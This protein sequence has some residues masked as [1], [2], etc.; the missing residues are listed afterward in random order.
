[1]RLMQSSLKYSLS[2]LMLSVSSRCRRILVAVRALYPLFTILQRTS[3]NIPT[4][5]PKA[6]RESREKNRSCLLL[7]NTRM[8]FLCCLSNLAKFLP[9]NVPKIQ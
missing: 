9:I 6:D 8:L 4:E 2:F 1:M 5:M 7:K 3:I